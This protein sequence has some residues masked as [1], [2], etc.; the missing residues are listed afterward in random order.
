MREV[1]HLFYVNTLGVD[2]QNGGYV[3]YLQIIN[4]ETIAKKSSG[5]ST[6]PGA[7][8]AKGHGATVIGA[9]HN[10]YA[11]T[12]RRI[13]WGHTT[14]LIFS[15]KALRHVGI[16][17]LLENPTRY[18]EFRYLPWV[19]CTNESIPDLM[20]IQPII[21]GSPI[22]SVLS[23]PIDMYGQSSCV[24]PQA[25]HS[26]IRDMFEPGRP[27]LIPELSIKKSDWFDVKKTY[28]EPVISGVGVLRNGRLLGSLSREQ[29]NGLRWFTPTAHR[30]IVTLRKKGKP[31]AVLTLRTPKHT[32]QAVLKGTRLSFD[33]QVNTDGYISEQM[34]QIPEK[35][36]KTMVAEEMEHEIRQTFASGLLFKTDIYGLSQSLYRRNPQA[37]RRWMRAGGNSLLHKNSL[38]H[39]TIRVAIRSSGRTME[40]GNHYVTGDSQAQ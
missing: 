33:I 32:V 24:T 23:D 25:L 7:W 6:R 12:Q 30:T 15:E 5:Q 31:V 1:E 17:E 4:P 26:M 9:I 20:N 2:Y 36:L 8:I 37:F 11:T 34:L 16:Q 40:P 29:L 21:E 19:C 28:P 38:R 27:S 22:F 14:S 39:I 35:Q 18:F 13:Y 3:V 10:I